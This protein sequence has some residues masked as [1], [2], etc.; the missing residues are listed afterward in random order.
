M[1]S[2]FYLIAAMVAALK[3][4][5]VTDVSWW[6]VLGTFCAGVLLDVATYAGLLLVLKGASR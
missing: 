3:L 1:G 2:I 6:V 5:L 4:C